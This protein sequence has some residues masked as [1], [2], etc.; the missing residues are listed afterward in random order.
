MTDETPEYGQDEMAHDL[1]RAEIVDRIEWLTAQ[2]VGKRV[3]H[4]GFAD[5]GFRL[6]Q[7]RAGRWLHGHLHEVAGELVGIDADPVGV[8]AATDDDFEAYVV[9]CTDTAAVAALGIEPAD[10]VLA[11]EV[12]EHVSAPGL[13][14]DAMHHLCK[15]EGILIVTT[16][17]AY[18]LINVAASITRRVE[19][20]H[21]DHVVMFTWRTLTELM[22]RSGW[23]HTRT[24]TY[25]PA[26][27]ERGNRSR[28][29]A[30]AVR[31]IVGVERLLG[32]LNRPFSAD[33]LIVSAKPSD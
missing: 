9:D 11:G 6:E 13:F 28:L 19:I 12:I 17:N 15:P 23:D 33:G 14:L 1:P 26:V 16:P 32:K 29:E 24:V 7:G 22:R 5:A 27:R 30:A 10:V 3:I 21:P 8:A 18:G 25:V 4:V 20:N 31:S 2:C